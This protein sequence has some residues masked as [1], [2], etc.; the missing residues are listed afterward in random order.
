VPHLETHTSTSKN[1]FDPGITPLW[2]M[3]SQASLVDALVARGT[4][5]DRA[6][7][8]TLAAEVTQAYAERGM[9]H[10]YWRQRSPPSVRK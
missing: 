9:G 4:P 10:F 5:D 6:R 3:H 8:K 2:A 7:A 1:A